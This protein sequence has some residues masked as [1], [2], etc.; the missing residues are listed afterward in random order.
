M[1]QKNYLE[2][3]NCP[4]KGANG[5]VLDQDFTPRELLVAIGKADGIYK[6]VRWFF[7]LIQANVWL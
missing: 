3:H 1:Y 6:M 7:G 2:W 4:L 5:T